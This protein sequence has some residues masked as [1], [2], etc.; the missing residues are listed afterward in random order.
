MGEHLADTQ[1]DTM[2]QE[3][4]D[5]PTWGP[6]QHERRSDHREDEMLQHV[7]AEEIAVS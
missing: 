6:Y 5:E 1:D 3:R 4:L 7:H 2:A